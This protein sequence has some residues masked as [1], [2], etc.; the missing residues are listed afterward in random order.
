MG[1]VFVPDNMPLIARGKEFWCVMAIL[2][3]NKR[4]SQCIREDHS[5]TGGQSAF[6][7]NALVKVIMFIWRA[8][9]DY[10]D[11]WNNLNWSKW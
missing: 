8:C 3:D 7:L 5:A 9:K 10:S 2:W 1:C 11:L 4:G 6:Y